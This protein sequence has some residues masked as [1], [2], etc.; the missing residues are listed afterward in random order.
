MPDRYREIIEEAEYTAKLDAL[1]DVSKL[2]AALAGLMWGLS[3]DPEQF[4]QVPGMDGYRIGKTIAL[5]GAPA[6]RVLFRID[7]SGVVVLVDV[8]RR[9]T[10][11]D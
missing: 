8:E 6:L 3:T 9:Q 7:A 11:T 10:A 1:G 4:D 5:Y 2:D